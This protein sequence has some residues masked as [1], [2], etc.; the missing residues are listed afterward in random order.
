MFLS[1]SQEVTVARKA[2]R[3]TVP[4]SSKARAKKKT[5]TT[6]NAK[7]TKK[8]VK[9]ATPAGPGLKQQFL[10]TFTR[11]HERTVRVLRAFPADQ[12]D[13]RPHERSNSARVLAFTFVLEQA[14]LTRSLM[15]DL[16]IGGGQMPKP[17]ATFA[18]IIDM[19]ERDFRDLV[20]LIR[21]TSEREFLTGTTQFFTGPK[22]MGS[23][24]KIDFAWFLLMDQI[25][26]RG[27]YTVYVRMA[28]G[29]V[30]S[31]YGPSA[32]EPWN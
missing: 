8:A 9:R 26:H 28:G 5:N 11:E 1:P 15:D 3:K 6:T 30:P 4:K 24:K 12:A 18:E 19:F 29:K 22:Q 20:A 31:V 17:P 2:A 21:K 10:D 14:L 7:A 32:D 27:Q 13:F 16:K 23:F 25:H